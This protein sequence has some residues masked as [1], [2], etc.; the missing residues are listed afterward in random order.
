M[1]LIK[2]SVLSASV[3][4]FLSLGVVSA[5]GFDEPDK[6][7]QRQFDFWIGEWDVNLRIR[8]KD[9]TW[10][11]RVKSVAR[12]YPILDGKAILELWSQSEQEINGYSLRYYNP[13]KD[14]WDLWLNWPGKNRSGT[15][16]MECSFRHKR[17]ECFSNSKGS[18]GKTTIKRYSFSDVSP[19]S[20]RWDD[21]F[22]KDGGN[23]WSN[24]WIMEFS[25]RRQT[26][27]SFDS[28]EKLLTYF[29]GGRCVDEQFKVLSDL[30]AKHKNSDSLKMYR[31]LDGC[32]VFGLINQNETKAFFKLTYN[33]YAKAY[34]LGFLDGS[35]SSAFALYYGSKT[36][37]GFELS[38]WAKADAKARK[39]V[40]GI[41]RGIRSIDI[42]YEGR[43]HS[44]KFR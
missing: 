34:E 37:K 9:F 41:N 26:P 19:T 25:R 38:R 17:A 22:S 21:A 32:A 31:I 40:I 39:A 27:P 16:G 42:D 14:K 36:E 44:F 33:T 1:K 12:I 18:D 6:S 4:V 20:L 30:T 28:T 3:F 5:F 7:K 24:N 13:K 8:Q 29:N 2:L 15:S 11:D 43:K 23:T 35:D 10:A